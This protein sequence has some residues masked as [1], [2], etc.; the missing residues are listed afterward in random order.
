MGDWRSVPGGPRQGSVRIDPLAR[1]ALLRLAGDGGGRP[2]E[3]VPPPVACPA[4]G[5]LHD[6]RREDDWH[7]EDCD[8]HRVHRCPCGAVRLDGVWVRPMEGGAGGA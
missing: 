8:G 3:P 1:A 7:D 5:A 4:C 2:V 6:P